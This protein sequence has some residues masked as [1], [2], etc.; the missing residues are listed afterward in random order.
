MRAAFGTVTTRLDRRVPA[1]PKAPD[2]LVHPAAREAVASRDL[3]RTAALAHDRV[4][5]VPSSP[6]VDTSL[7]QKRCPLSPETGVRYH[8]NSDT[9]P[10]AGVVKPDT[11]LRRGA[12]PLTPGRDSSHLA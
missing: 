7:P 3:A 11:T 12:R 9:T 5:H 4:D 10:S 6:H 2:Q 8:L 1:G